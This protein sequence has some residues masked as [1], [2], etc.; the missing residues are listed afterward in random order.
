MEDDPQDLL[1]AILNISIVFI[2]LLLKQSRTTRNIQ[3]C[4]KETYLEDINCRDI[5]ENS[6]LTKIKLK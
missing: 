6:A 3:I 1:I 5:Y 4:K 2:V